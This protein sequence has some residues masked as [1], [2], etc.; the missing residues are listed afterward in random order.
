YQYYVNNSLNA[1]LGPTSPTRANAGGMRNNE[2]NLNLDASKLFAFV[3]ES[4]LVLSGGIAYRKNSYKIFQGDEISYANYGYQD[5]A[6]GMQGFGGFTPESTV[7]ESRNNVGVYVEVENQ[8]TEQFN[9]A[10]AVRQEHYSD[11]GSDT[12]WKLAG[13]YELTPEWA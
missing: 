2:Q 10:A 11:F 6:G 4:D 9:W 8:L 1:S 13:R 12:S 7:D 3:N 5:K